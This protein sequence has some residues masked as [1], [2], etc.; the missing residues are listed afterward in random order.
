MHIPI[1]P[2]ASAI[3]D[4][5]T[6]SS[7]KSHQFTRG[8]NPKVVWASIRSLRTRQ[9]TASGRPSHLRWEQYCKQQVAVHN[10]CV[11]FDSAQCLDHAGAQWIQHLTPNRTACL[12]PRST[13]TSFS[14]SL[15]LFIRT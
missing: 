1:P 12:C 8:E 6:E 2:P 10:E 9:E 7:C 15:A 11:I 5:T 14:E 4:E 13:P 3:K